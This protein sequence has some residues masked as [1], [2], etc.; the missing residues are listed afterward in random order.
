MNVDNYREYL[1]RIGHCV[2]KSESGYWFD[3]G[4][5]MYESIPPF[6]Q[7]N[8]SEDEIRYL[9]R[10]HH[11]V[12]I[13]YCTDMNI[14]VGKPSFLYVCEDPSY[15]IDSLGRQTRRKIRQGLKECQVH[16]IDFECLYTQGMP[17]NQDT[18]ARQKR[19]DSNFDNP[20]GWRRFCQAAS[21][22]EGALAWGAFVGDQLTAYTFGFV[23]DDYCILIYQMSRTEII[24]LHINQA[25]TYTATREILSLPDIHCVSQGHETIR[26]LPGLDTYKVRMGYTKRPLRQVVK[27]HPLAKP[28]MLSSVGRHS[29]RRF[30]R[31]LP[32]SDPLICAEG[33]LNI[34]QHSYGV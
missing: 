8:P 31:W 28:V 20:A 9:F 17:A 11:M 24:H 34:A 14:M 6:A 30:R 26:D 18:L 5:R 3:A 25:L 1:E 29:L 16:R 23:I 21:Q 2:I 15:A 32:D 12:G 33:I 4:P 19:S 27:L 7:I 10:R 22:V 13:K